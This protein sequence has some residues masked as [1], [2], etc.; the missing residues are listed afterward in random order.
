MAPNN[1]AAANAR[2]LEDAI[3]LNMQAPPFR[4]D[5][6]HRSFPAAAFPTGHPAATDIVAFSRIVEVCEDLARS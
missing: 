6:R 4:L 3:T 2:Q 5:L 1:A